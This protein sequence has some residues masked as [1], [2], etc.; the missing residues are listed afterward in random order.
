MAEP[1]DR[2]RMTTGSSRPDIITD[3]IAERVPQ[4]NL[5]NDN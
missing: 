2:H 1:D 4:I 5:L 3:A